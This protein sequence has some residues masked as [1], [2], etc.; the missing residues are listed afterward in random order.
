MKN[1][2]KISL[3]AWIFI[4]MIA[5]AL[6]GLFCGDFML[7]FEFIGTIWLNLLK[8][9]VAPLTMCV[10][11]MAIGNQDNLGSVGRVALRVFCYFVMTTVVAA[12]LG[13]VVGEV[14]KPGLN[15][16][17]TGLATSDID[18]GAPIDLAS[19]AMNLISSNLFA[20]LAE[21]N[22][23]Q[24]L[25]IGIL[26][27]IAILTIKDQKK[28][29]AILDWFQA[30]NDLIF[31]YVNIVIKLSP[32]GVFFLL[33]S[34]FA[35]YGASILSSMAKLTGSFYVGLL[36]QIL[37]VYCVVLWIVCKI[38]PLRYLKETMPVWTFTLATCSSA[39]NVPISINVATEK[40]G[41]RKK[42]ADF[43]IPLGAQINC[44]GSTVLTALVFLFICQANGVPYNV[45]TIFQVVMVSTIISFSGSGIPNGPLV[46]LMIV[47]ST[48][49]LPMEIIGIMAGFFRIFDMGSTMCNCMGD[50][51]GTIAISHMEEKRD[52]KLAVKNAES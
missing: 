26:F 43:I 51:A 2:K 27:G 34:A 19:F 33:S 42:I 12:I 8:L 17:L 9:I 41:V 18:M 3:N 5:G 48:F 24:V 52:A 23:L 4:A 14:F 20:S 35:N 22:V 46:K 28:K 39:A 31:A 6:L 32:I 15:A 13:L 47:V 25:I 1:L 30:M 44:D 45:F 11:V 50:L 29:D 16:N 7:K 36:L 10:M 21:G 40:F 37:L 49:G 38:N